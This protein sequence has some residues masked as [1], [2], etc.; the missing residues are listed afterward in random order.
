MSFMSYCLLKPICLW[1]SLLRDSL[2]KRGKKKTS[3]CAEENSLREDYASAV[4]GITKSVW[5]E[6]KRKGGCKKDG[7]QTG[8]GKA[9]FEWEG[10]CFNAS[11]MAM[12]GLNPPSG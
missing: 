3:L 1:N 6:E 9:V 4:D 11:V 8:D 5:T 7:I 10:I 2:Q 12:D